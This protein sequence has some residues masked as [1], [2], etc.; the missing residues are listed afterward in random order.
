MGDGDPD[1][2]ADGSDDRPDGWTDRHD[3]AELHRAARRI[4]RRRRR[5]RQADADDA[6][7]V[8][9]ASLPAPLRER[10]QTD[11]GDRDRLEPTGCPHG[12]CRGTLQDTPA[13][14]NVWACDTCGDWV[15]RATSDTDGD[16]SDGD[17]SDGD[18]SGDVMAA[19]S[20]D[21]DPTHSAR[22]GRR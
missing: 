4:R 11:G 14:P 15:M 21:S 6:D 18:G 8:A 22:V 2:D 9:S 13:A 7:S 10:A 1:P 20:D 12:S 5:Q 19:W 3:R 16:D 17:D